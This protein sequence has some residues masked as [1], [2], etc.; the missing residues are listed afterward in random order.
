MDA[1]PGLYPLLEAARLG[2][3]AALGA[4]LETYRDYL[5]LLA[6]VSVGHRLQAKIDGSDLVQETFVQAVRSFDRFRGRTEPELR[7]WLRR[8]LASRL[9]NTL[10]HY[11][12]TERRDL[13]AERELDRSSRA[14]QRILAVSETSPSAAASRN[15][16]VV[17][18]ASA[19]ERLPEDYRTVILLRHV[20]GL[21]FLRVAEEMERSLGSVEKLWARALGR[22]REELED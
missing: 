9:S 7:G 16:R 1:E 4:A 13:N 6:R 14:L 8:I 15:E 17:L 22:L 5:R 3:E 10:R 18:L 2:D 21:P 20:Q 11:Y 19:I 12:G